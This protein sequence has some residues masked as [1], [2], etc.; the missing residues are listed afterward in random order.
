MEKLTYNF[1]VTNT[2]VAFQL[3]N[4]CGEGLIDTQAAFKFIRIID[5]Y[6]PRGGNLFSA[7]GDYDDRF[8]ETLLNLYRTLYYRELDSYCKSQGYADYSMVSKEDLSKLKAITLNKYVDNVTSTNSKGKSISLTE[9][10]C[11]DIAVG[12]YEDAIKGVKEAEE[13]LDKKSK[14][15]FGIKEDKTIECEN[16]SE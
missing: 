16:A 6:K 8:G 15:Y 4:A 10:A 2:S 1:K 11:C 5:E 14:K 9:F 12:I 7:P 3:G 13:L